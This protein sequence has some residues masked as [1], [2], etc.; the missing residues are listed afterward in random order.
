MTYR[1]PTALLGTVQVATA[2][3]ALASEASSPAFRDET[4]DG[5]Q[6]VQAEHGLARGAR[7]AGE[8][9]VEHLGA[10]RH[11]HG[12]RE[13]PARGADGGHLH[14]VVC[15]PVHATQERH[16][17]VGLVPLVVL[18]QADQ[19]G[20][21]AFVRVVAVAGLP[22]EE[23]AESPRAEAVDVGDAELFVQPHVQLEVR[24]AVEN[25]VFE[26][27]GEVRQLPGDQGR[28]V[29]E[30]LLPVGLGHVQDVRLRGVDGRARSY[31]GYRGGVVEVVHHG[32]GVVAGFHGGDVAQKT[33]LARAL[34]Q[35]AARD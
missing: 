15:G 22:R 1:V 28:E 2:V 17:G 23:V 34:E 26:G 6:A 20:V 10:E 11:V 31:E 9:R 21:V 4:V 27:D 14:H 33:L 8:N 12:E 7:P 24:A 35:S 19:H 3:I 32:R 29:G 18:A 25:L 16:L 30:E 13:L 5:V